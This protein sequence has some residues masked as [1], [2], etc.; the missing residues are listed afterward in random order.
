MH[1]ATYKQA[2]RNVQMNSD[3]TILEETKRQ[4][5]CQRIIKDNYFPTWRVSDLAR[6]TG[7][8]QCCSSAS[9]GSGGIWIY[10][11]V[12]LC[13]CFPTSLQFISA[14][15]GNILVSCSQ[16]SLPGSCLPELQRRFCPFRKGL[17]FRD[18]VTKSIRWIFFS[19]S[20]LWK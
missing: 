18:A 20:E 7:W 12:L 19:P 10:S 2:N 5:R 17:W 13:C 3:E 11:L 15:S 1:W 9:R 4:S 14:T 16:K 6:E 8:C